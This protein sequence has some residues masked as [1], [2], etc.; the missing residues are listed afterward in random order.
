MH[1]DTRIAAASVG[2]AIVGKTVEAYTRNPL[3]SYGGAAVGGVLGSS[4]TSFGMELLLVFFN[5]ATL[6]KLEAYS[7]AA[8]VASYA[9][10]SRVLP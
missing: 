2:G 4:V 1:M 5:P 10:I 9:V 6:F 7:A 3:L 8:G